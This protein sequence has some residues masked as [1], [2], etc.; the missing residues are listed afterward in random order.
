LAV[1][2]TLYRIALA[3]APLMVSIGLHVR[4]LA[5][6]EYC[7]K[8]IYTDFLTGRYIDVTHL[9]PCPID[10]TAFPTDDVRDGW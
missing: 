8:E 2:A 7:Y 6:Q 9:W 5:I 1:S 10:L 4:I 3:F